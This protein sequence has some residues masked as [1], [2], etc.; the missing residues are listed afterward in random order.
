MRPQKAATV[1]G[2]GEKRNRHSGDTR[3]TDSRNKRTEGQTRL[4]Q[5]RSKAEQFCKQIA[6]LLLQV[7]RDAQ[8]YI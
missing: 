1:Q 7:H 2:E 3:P 6:N 4:E 5:V 8:I